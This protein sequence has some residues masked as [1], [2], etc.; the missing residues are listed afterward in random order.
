MRGDISVPDL[1]HVTTL[2]VKRFFTA[3]NGPIAPVFR[4]GF[5]G[6]PTGECF[7]T[8]ERVKLSNPKKSLFQIV[9]NLAAVDCGTRFYGAVQCAARELGRSPY[10]LH[11]VMQGVGGVGPPDGGPPGGG[12]SAAET[13]SSSPLGVMHTSSPGATSFRRPVKV[14]TEIGRPLITLILSTQRTSRGGFPSFRGSTVT[15]TTVPPLLEI[16]CAFAPLI[17]V[18]NN[19]IIINVGIDL[20]LYIASKPLSSPFPV[21]SSQ[22]SSL[23]RSVLVRKA[24]TVPIVREFGER[25]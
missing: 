17:G 8:I 19:A 12:G 4:R 18:P 10:R 3:P 6:T 2:W 7:N 21:V 1:R 20:R 23:P 24:G 5:L 22:P 14:C 9:I 13:V 15:S 16:D 11:I 25:R